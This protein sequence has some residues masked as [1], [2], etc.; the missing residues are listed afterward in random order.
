MWNV[1]IAVCCKVLTQ[2]FKIKLTDL[3]S[4]RTV[5]MG[6]L[7]WAAQSRDTTSTLDI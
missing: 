6:D 7:S 3:V 5:Y 4:L 1:G 2:N